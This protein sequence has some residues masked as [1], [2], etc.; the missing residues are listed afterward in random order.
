M[1][2]DDHR[3]CFVGDSLVHGA[4]DAQCRGWP[5]RITADARQRGLN[6]AH[7]NLGVR[8]DTSHEIAVRWHLECAIRLPEHVKR[9]VVF[10]F[11]VNDIT[12]ENGVSRVSEEDSM[13]NFKAIISQASSLY[14]IAVIGPSPV[15]DDARN[16]RIS[17]LSKLFKVAAQHVHVPYL[18][19]FDA[20][21]ADTLWMSQVQ[22]NDGS[23]PATEG[24]DA[25]A[26][27]V[28]AWPN[29]WFHHA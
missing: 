17:H 16:R 8:A 4:G 6:I 11:G 14:Q 18:P 23:H 5:G 1:D 20:L 2:T 12:Q 13:K 28:I 7:Y 15:A 21:L 9:Y 22:G 27:L 10:S 24:Y 29:W 19:V 25:L 3:I 26:K